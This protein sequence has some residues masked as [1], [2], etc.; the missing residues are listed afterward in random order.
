MTTLFPRCAALLAILL[1]SVSAVAHSPCQG[2][3]GAVNANWDSFYAGMPLAEES[4]TGPIRILDYIG[5]EIGYSD[6]R[7]APLWV[8]Y[9]LFTTSDCTIP[10][11]PGAASD[12][13]VPGT[14][15]TDYCY[16][17]GVRYD[18]GHMAPN[19]M[20][21][22]CY[23]AKAQ[24]QASLMTNICP[25]RS[26]M[27][28]GP[29]KEV[30][31]LIKQDLAT[32]GQVWVICG[33]IFASGRLTQPRA[34]SCPLGNSGEL[35]QVADQFYAILIHD[36]DGAPGVSAYVVPQTASRT[37]SLAELARPVRAIEDA[38]NL[39]FLWMIE[40]GLEDTLETD[41][42]GSPG[43]E[44]LTT[45][46]GF[47]VMICGVL[48]NA[49]GSDEVCNEAIFLF[50]NGDAEVDLTGTV[51]SDTNHSWRIAA[52]RSTGTALNVGG[53][54]VC[55]GCIYNPAGDCN[56][57]IALSNE[58]ENLTLSWGTSKDEWKYR[59]ASVEKEIIIRAGYEY[60]A[61]QLRQ[62]YEGLVCP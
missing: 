25:Q 46:A 28:A 60:L 6:S 51:L 9:R 36:E 50:N 45:T 22:K 41:C 11:R 16:G 30:E 54:W 20:I 38:T 10:D 14:T 34:F 24:K 37:A 23:G 17:D 35:P 57:G 27:H 47:G 26:D 32:W 2:L 21:A 15:A 18:G 43:G 8:C 5:F 44:P 48:A 61:D 58:G 33:P 29:W 3:P 55:K 39:N 56:C 31:C 7:R 19:A 40:D 52:T 4:V 42:T 53:I 12:P 1:T 13:D 49:E 59:N 62:A